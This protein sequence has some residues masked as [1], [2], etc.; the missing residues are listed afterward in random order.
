MQ[1]AIDQTKPHLIIIDDELD[2]CEELSE[3]LNS[4]GISTTY[5]TDPRDALA[6]VNEYRPKVVLLDINMPNLNGLRVLE[7]LIGLG[8]QGSIILMS[9]SVDL[10][11]DANMLQIVKNNCLHVIEKPINVGALVRYANTVINR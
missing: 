6:Y 8:Y 2:Q 1:Y 4:S 10:I 3:I 5:E 11:R 7:I 9:G